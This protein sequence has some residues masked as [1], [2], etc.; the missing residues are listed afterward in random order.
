M[1]QLTMP[2]WARIDVRD[3][4][5][6]TAEMNH[7][8]SRPVEELALRGIERQANMLKRASRRIVELPGLHRRL[9]RLERAALQ[10]Y[11]HFLYD[12]RMD[13]I[14]VNAAPTRFQVFTPRQIDSLLD[15]ASAILFIL[16]LA[17][18]SPDLPDIPSSELGQYHHRYLRH[19]S[20]A[21]QAA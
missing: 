9:L 13:F 18:I 10:H 1:S 14:A 17:G 6:S 16:D 5:A 7:A 3:L 12:D 19:T 2:A 4:I 21:K 11:P 8:P 15:E 20:R